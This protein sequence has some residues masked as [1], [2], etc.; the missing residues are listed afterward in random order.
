MF[1]GFNAEF[2][3]S[4]REAGLPLKTAVQGERY[5]D[6]TFPVRGDRRQSDLHVSKDSEEMILR[7][8]RISEF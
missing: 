8:E 6:R 3:C 4:A 7:I 2:D 5:R 1:F